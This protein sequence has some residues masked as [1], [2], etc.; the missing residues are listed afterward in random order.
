MLSRVSFFVATPALLMLTL[1]EADPALLFSAGLLATVGSACLCVLL[2]AGLARWR[3]RL[4]PAELATGALASSY[5]N[6]ANLGVPISAYVLG[7]AS[8]VAPVL[9]FQLLVM[10]PVGLAVLAGSHATARAPSRWVVLTSPLRTPWWWVAHL[11]CCSPPPGCVCRDRRC[12]R[13][14]SSPPSPFRRRCSPTA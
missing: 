7:D 4:R 6:A 2:Y 11:G 9:L 8:F 10:A 14:S 1:A 5:V 13:W 3:W 12:S